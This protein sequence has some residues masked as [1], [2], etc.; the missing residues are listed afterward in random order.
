M[1][2]FGHSLTT[3]CSH[4]C[5]PEYVVSPN[6]YDILEDVGPFF[7]SVVTPLTFILVYAW[8]V[9]IGTVSLFYCGEYPG[10]SLFGAL[11]H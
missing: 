1:S 11:V 4:V 7:G 9:A 5:N 8:P 6:R 2:V 3:S 10:S